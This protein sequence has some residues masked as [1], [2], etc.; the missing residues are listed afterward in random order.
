MAAASL[1]QD[2]DCKCLI[3]VAPELAA[4]SGNGR[5]DRAIK[6]MPEA[7]AVGSVEDSRLGLTSAYE[8]ACLA[9]LPHLLPTPIQGTASHNCRLEQ[10]RRGSVAASVSDRERVVFASDACIRVHPSGWSL[11]KCTRDCAQFRN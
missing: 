10:K 5:R 1:M 4:S 2:L 9:S 8:P 7:S 11:R 6:R 3:V